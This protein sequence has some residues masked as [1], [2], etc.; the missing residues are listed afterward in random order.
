[1]FLSNAQLNVL[2]LSIFL[3]LGA[4]HKWSRINYPLLDDP[5]QHLDDLD[6]LAFVDSLRAVA[7]GKFGEKKQIIVSTCDE[8]LYRLMIQWTRYPIARI[9]ETETT[10]QS[11]R[12]GP[13]TIRTPGPEAR[14]AS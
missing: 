1:M 4:G 9:L 3:S 6:A 11:S 5:V 14:I 8:N 10:I 7:L 13:C 2:A 12:K